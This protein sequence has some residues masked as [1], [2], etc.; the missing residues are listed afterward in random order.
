MAQLMLVAWTWHNTFFI[1]HAC[2]HMCA[3]KTDDIR[4]IIQSSCVHIRRVHDSLQTHACRSRMHT[5]NLDYVHTNCKPRTAEYTLW[6]CSHVHVLIIR[7][8]SPHDTRCKST[9]EFLTVKLKWLKGASFID[10]SI[11]DSWVNS[12][13]TN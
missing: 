6:T 7:C 12:N 4:P 2:K 8:N 13:V 3:H 1:L 10:S 9:K 11:S 5:P